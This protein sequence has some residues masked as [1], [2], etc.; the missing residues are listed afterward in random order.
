MGVNSMPVLGPAKE[1]ARILNDKSIPL[2]YDTFVCRL[3]ETLHP[4]CK[5]WST[6]CAKLPD[7]SDVKTRQLYAGR[8]YFQP[9]L[10]LPTELI[11]FVDDAYR[12]LGASYDVSKKYAPTASQKDPPT[13]QS[14]MAIAQLIRTI[15]KCSNGITDSVLEEF[16]VHLEVAKSFCSRDSR[17]STLIRSFPT[18]YLTK[19][20]DA[21]QDGLQLMNFCR[22]ST[23]EVQGKIDS[24]SS[25]DSLCQLLK[26]LS[27][28]ARE[29]N[30]CPQVEAKYKAIARKF[31]DFDFTK[32]E[33]GK[34]FSLAGNFRVAP[35][36]NSPLRKDVS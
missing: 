11:G 20:R 2:V 22:S 28:N 6:K 14:L 35:I 13:R 10:P 21:Y 8:L 5:A 9:V 27:T 19:A 4:L 29:E 15:S 24:L 7:P 36:L 3:V 26:D 34:N 16:Y 30:E 12:F 17:L 18:T 33:P 23:L 1:C 25:I 31:N 32:L